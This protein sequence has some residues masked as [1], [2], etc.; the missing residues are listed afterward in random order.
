M[1][2]WVS[3][4]LVL[5]LCKAFEENL[6]WELN[7]E[8]FQASFEYQPRMMILFWSRS[9]EASQRIHAECKLAAKKLSTHLIRIGSVNCDSFPS[10][11]SQ[12]N[13][14][15]TPQYLYFDAGDH[16]E[17]KDSTNAEDVF[18]YILPR[19]K[20]SLEYLKQTDDVFSLFKANRISFLYIGKDSNALKI[21]KDLSIKFIETVFYVSELSDYKETMRTSSDFVLHR[22][23]EMVFYNGEIELS[24]IETFLKTQSPVK[25]LDFNEE[26][27]KLVFDQK[28]AALFLFRKEV[29][30]NKFQDFG[31]LADRYEGKFVF[32][33]ADLSAKGK[34]INKLAH[35]LG[36]NP[37]IQPLVVLLSIK[38]TFYKYRTATVDF[39]G[40]NDF[41]NSYYSGTLLQYYKSEAIPTEPSESG[42][43]EIVG[44][45]HEETVLNPEKDVLALYFTVQHPES[46]SIL[47][48]FEKLALNYEH[49][50]NIQLVKMDIVFNEAKDLIIPH[51][52]LI[53]FYP[54]HNKAGIPYSGD[55]T[56]FGLQSFVLAQF[57]PPTP[58]L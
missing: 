34:N 1:K 4:F 45:N 5:V 14:T 43:I 29:E 58:D 20:S 33:A 52:P 46:T 35:A 32:V 40:L 12:Y 27:I 15:Q 30:R 39:E 49:V 25:I 11:C 48:I 8:N 55:L 42:V 38:E 50:P 19:Y 22:G 41:I 6:I 13:V 23:G 7:S 26:T 37:N 2:T 54:R 21:M 44:L 53:K 18:K 9:T 51:L 10:L 17:Y 28:K 16:Y 56:L 47:P 24:A 31:K 3:F 36:L 57:K